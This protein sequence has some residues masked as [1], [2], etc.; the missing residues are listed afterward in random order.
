MK[1]G[2]HMS[3]AGGVANALRRGADVGCETIQIF[4]KNNN[5]WQGK[6]ITDGER[7]DFLALRDRSG[8]APVFAH[9]A[10]LINP[11]APDPEVHE[12]SLVAL[13]DEV[14][15]CEALELSYL[16]LHP[17]AHKGEGESAGLARI[18][19]SLD[20]VHDETPGARV[21]ILLET[22]AG[23]GTSLGHTFDQL[24]R[25]MTGVSRPER[26]GVCLDSCHVFAAGYDIRRRD[27]YEAMMDEFGTLIG[28]DNL[29]A[30]HLND[31]RRECGSRVD[32]HDHIGQGVMGL[33]P[34]R[35]LVNDPRLEDVPGVLETPKNEACD[36]DR[37]NLKTLRELI[38]G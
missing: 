1:L 17:G 9:T 12:R 3:I 14:E 6:P 27:G 38:D 31:S 10:Y 30:I 20:R 18:A 23:Q 36:E 16:V 29:R 7:A 8:I 32:R 37:L 34:F 13:R 35:F 22:T 21:K 2:A 4:T 11:A 26:L 5:R 28:F 33:A 19:R 25:I 15:R 24:R